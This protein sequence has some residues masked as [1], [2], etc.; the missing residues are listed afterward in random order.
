MAKE[1]TFRLW[2]GLA[3]LLTLF[4]TASLADMILNNSIIH[5]E[6]GKPSRQDIMVENSADEPLY[7]KV[8]P[9]SI[10]NPGTEQQNREKII[11]PKESGLLVSPNKLVVPPGGRKLIR[12]V[13]LN[14]RGDKESVYRVTI[15]P[16]TGELVGKETGLKLLIGYEVLVLAQPVKLNPRLVAKRAGKTLSL[17][18]QGNTNI[19]LMQGKQCPGENTAAEDCTTLRDKRLY[20][21]NKWTVSLPHDGPLQY[22]LAIGTK[23][24]LRP[25]P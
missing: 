10:L 6:P 23:N 1:L 22:Q 19:Y 17:S 13:N 7:I 5:F 25:I 12:F 18:N 15:E 14:P 16:V 24:S 4:P 8:T 9:Y 11:N 2:L 20:P 3:C 21:G